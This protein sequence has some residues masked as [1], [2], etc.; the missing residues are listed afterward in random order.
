[1]L[2]DVKITPLVVERERVLKL[3]GI[4]IGRC[5]QSSCRSQHALRTIIHLPKLL[6][7]ISV[8]FLIRTSGIIKVLSSRKSQKSSQKST[9]KS[10]FTQKSTFFLQSHCTDLALPKS[11]HIL[12]PMD[13]MHS[14]RL[15]HIYAK[16]P[17]DPNQ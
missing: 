13:W 9:Q 6:T 5:L 17:L 11:S 8:S 12:Q 14:N 16:C 7:P 1:M 10:S 15:G 3:P 2:L 4:G